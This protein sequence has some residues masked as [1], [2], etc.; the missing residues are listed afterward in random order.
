MSFHAT[1]VETWLLASHAESMPQLSPKAIA[2]FQ[3]LWKK[4]Y[5]TELPPEQAV[6]RA[7]QLIALVRLLASESLASSPSNPQA[8]PIPSIRASDTSQ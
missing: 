6:T 4:H 5:G 2:E 1:L 8:D 3:A 7:H